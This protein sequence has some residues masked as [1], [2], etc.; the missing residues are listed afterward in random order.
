VAI[1]SVMIPIVSRD[2]IGGTLAG[3]VETWRI[4]VE[5][6]GSSPVIG[7]GGFPLSGLGQ[8][9]QAF[10]AH[11]Q[12]LQAWAEG[13]VV[14]I[15]LLTAALLATLRHAREAHTRLGLSALVGLIATFPFESP[16]R[17]YAPAF[18][19]TLLIVLILANVDDTALPSKR[20]QITQ[21]VPEPALQ[22]RAVPR[23]GDPDIVGAT[24]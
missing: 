22:H 12:L 16:V 21:R 1:A 14:G 15:V 7:G 23:D 5:L 9:S 18:V 20:R 2:A 10:Y 6:G 4:A 3:R 8:P 17:V 11:S 13:G 19:T 24:R